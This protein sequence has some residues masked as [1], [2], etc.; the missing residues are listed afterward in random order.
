MCMMFNKLL[1][2]LTATSLLTTVWLISNLVIEPITTTVKV[3]DINIHACVRTKDSVKF[4]REFLIYHVAQGINSFS[5]YD[6]SV[7][8]DKEFFE[9]FPNVINYQH[10]NGIKIGN[11]NHFIL[12]CLSAAIMSGEYDY[13]LNMDDDEFLFSTVG[14]TVG[15]HLVDNGY[16]WFKYNDCVSNALYFFGTIKSNNSGYTTIDF[17]NRDR[18]VEGK[19][20]YFFYRPYSKRLKKRIKKSIFKVPVNL[21][22]KVDLISHFSKYIKTGVMIHGYSKNC[23]DQTLIKVAHYTRDDQELENRIKTFWSSVKGLRKRF[24]NEKSVYKYLKERNRTEVVDTRLRN[25]SKK[26]FN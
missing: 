17:V 21:T 19:D 26:I 22:D 5:I 2:T 15:K 10:V 16:S 12:K 7:K 25:K 18:D 9:S 20:F 13:V 4:M 23:T 3:P 6:D 11:E 8:S 24:S 1:F 14:E